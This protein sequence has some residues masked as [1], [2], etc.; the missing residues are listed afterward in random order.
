MYCTSN[1]AIDALRCCDVGRDASDGKS[2]EVTESQTVVT[3]PPLAEW[4][5]VV[6]C[7]LAGATCP[8]PANRLRSSLRAKSPRYYPKF[9]L[10]FILGFLVIFAVLYRPGLDQ[11]DELWRSEDY[12]A[13]S[14]IAFLHCSSLI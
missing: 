1:L 10:V 12:L 5:R 13:A 9:R 2:R 7:L 8:P 3:P 11:L 14:G 4:S 6:C